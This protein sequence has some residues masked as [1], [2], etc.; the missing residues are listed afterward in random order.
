[1]SSRKA[2]LAVVFVLVIASLACNPMSFLATKTPTITPSPTPTDTPTNTPT[3]TPTNTPIATDTPKVPTKDLRFHDTSGDIEFS[4]IPPK[5]WQKTDSQLGADTAW[6]HSSGGIMD[7]AIQGGESRSASEV[8]D[9]VAH[10]MQNN[11]S[12]LDVIS[13][14]P[15]YPDAGIDTYKVVLEYTSGEYSIHHT[16]YL[17]VDQGYLLVVQYIRMI[18]TAENLD[19]GVDNCMMTMEIGGGG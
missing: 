18:G 2:F 7:F 8:A 15:F 17:F 13:S 10:N 14:D 6:I 19:S 3:F 11:Y 5:G 12:G 9:T 4:Y 16:Y 1:M